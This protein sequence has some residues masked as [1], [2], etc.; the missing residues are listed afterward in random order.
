MKWIRTIKRIWEFLAH[1]GDAVD[2]LRVAFP[3]LDSRLDRLE[4]RIGLAINIR[5]ELVELHGDVKDILRTVPDLSPRVQHTLDRLDAGLT[6]ILGS[7]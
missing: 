2:G 3:Q 7:A 4:A 1:L 5:R 6:R